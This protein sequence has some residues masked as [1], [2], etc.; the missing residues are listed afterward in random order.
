MSK[1]SFSFWDGRLG[2]DGDRA[3]EIPIEY[4]REVER[5]EDA[6]QAYLD[7]KAILLDLIDELNGILQDPELKPLLRYPIDRAEQRLREVSP[8]ATEAGGAR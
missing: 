2:P 4:Q 7:A 8:A 5:A 6:R 1:G 3:V